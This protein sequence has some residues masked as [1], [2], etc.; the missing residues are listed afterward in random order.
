M[1]EYGLAAIVTPIRKFHCILAKRIADS[2]HG[3]QP[4]LQSSDS[5]REELQNYNKDCESIKIEQERMPRIEIYWKGKFKGMEQ[6]IK[7]MKN[8][9]EVMKRQDDTTR[10]CKSP[11]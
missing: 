7:R 1:L 2:E 10:R 6:E 3:W 11:H 8:E 4:K 9:M 5:S